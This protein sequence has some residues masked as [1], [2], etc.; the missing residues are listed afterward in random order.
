MANIQLTDGNDLYAEPAYDPARRDTVYSLGGDDTVRLYQGTVSGGRG[1]DRIEKLPGGGGLNAAY[2]D[3][4]VGVVAN[5]AEGWADDGFGTRD[6]LVGVDTITGNPGNDRVVGNEASNTF[7]ANDGHDTF[8]GAG[9]HDTVH[10]WFNPPGESNRVAR[11]DELVVRVSADGRRAEV[12]TRVGTSFTLSLLDVEAL[13]VVLPS[14]ERGEVLL[15][16]FITMQTLAEDAIAAG[17]TMRWNA[18]LP[19]GSA[20]TLT[21]SFVRADAR[22]G[23][24]SFTAAEQQAVRDILA[25]TA[26]LAGLSFQEVSEGQG[27]VGQLRFGVS[28][29][30][31]SKGQAALPGT[32]GDAAGDVWMDVESMAQGLVPGSEGYAALLHEIGHALGLRHPRNTDPGENWSLQLRPA[33]DRPGLTVMSS[34]ASADGLFRADWGV[35][36]LIALRYLYGTR[37]VNTGDNVYR[38]GTRESAAEHTLVDDGGHDLID[39]SQ[40]LGGVTLDL[41]PGHLGSAGLTSAGF[42]GVENLGLAWGSL[43]EDA[44]GSPFDDVLIGNDG[45]NALTGGLGNDWIDGGP[46]LDRAVFAGPRDD[47][48]LSNAFGTLYVAARDGSSGYDSLT[49]IEQLVFADQTVALA[50]AALGADAEFGIDEDR[51]LSARLPD[52]ADTARSGASYRLVGDAL[53]GQARISADGQLSYTPAADFHGSDRIVY[54]LSNAAGSNR[55][56]AFVAVQSVNDGPPVARD[57][58]LLAPTGATLRGSLPV[59]TDIDHDAIAYAASGGAGNGEA[60]VSA[61]GSFRYTPAAGFRGNDSF[62]FA[63]GDGSGASNA[64]RATVVV[65]PVAQAREGSAGADVLA[66]QATDD[67]LLGLAGNDRLTGGGGNDVINGGA[68]VDTAVY[69]GARGQYQVAKAAFGWTVRDGTGKEGQDSLADIE[70]LAFAGSSVALDLDGHAGSTAQ[71]IRALFGAVHLANPVFVGIGLS[72]FDAGLSYADVVGLAVATDE[73]AALAGGRSNAAF[74]TAVYKNLAGVAPAP[75]ELAAYV[76]LLDA[77]V[78]TQATLALAACQLPLNTQSIELVGFAETGIAYSPAGPA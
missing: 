5:L 24:R 7:V 52:P 11:L 14:G 3:S 55:Y 50:A 28:Q 38:L 58:T 48:L 26:S 31:A 49:R 70:R 17:G 68:G 33:D 72:L 4:P 45:P 71:I 77:G 76:G 47:Y 23:F 37:L 12:S 41:V 13:H 65:M 43:I 22:A 32:Q 59:A 27:A 78:Y 15:S 61:D 60:V 69:G 25:A 9:G 35:L 34:V 21:F 67:G 56:Q 63:V 62:G 36:D 10:C 64:Y 18:A 74:V 57:V 73:F 44:I 29:Q 16:S 30:A 46:G 8:D 66:G 2:W 54:E 39:A 1:N 6:T 51:S 19:V 40:Q 53:H 75:A 20:S 42:L